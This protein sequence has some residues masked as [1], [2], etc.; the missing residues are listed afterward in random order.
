PMRLVNGVA[1]EAPDANV[2]IE[3][4]ARTGI[5]SNPDIYY[6]FT[7]MGTRVVVEQARYQGKLKNQSAAVTN[8]DGLGGT[9][10]LSTR[11]KP[12]LRAGIEYDQ[13][14]WTFWSFPTTE[15]DRPLNL[16]RGSH[17]QIKVVLHSERFDEFVRL[18]S[19]WIETSPIL[20]S[21]VVAE[22]AQLGQPNPAR[23]VA[24]VPLGEMT[25]F[26]YD[27]KAEFA[28]GEVGFDALR[29]STGS[30]Q[31]EFKALEVDGIATDPAGIE[32]ADNGFVVQ[33][34]QRISSAYSP[35]LR[36][37]FA[38]EVF[39]FARTFEG[40]VF[41]SGGTELP[42]PIESGDVSDA[43]GTNSLRVLAASAA[44]PQLV[45]DVQ[46]SSG[47]ITPNGDGVNDEL[48]ISYSLF[49]LPQSVPVQLQVFSLDGRQVAQVQHGQQGSGP[50]RLSWD[51]RDQ[52]GET[53]VPG[54]YL[55]GIGIEAEDKSALQL[56][57]INI[58]Y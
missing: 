5:D 11:P 13:Q 51:G 33:L 37:T 7:D 25:D 27:I 8:A 3:V 54:L 2:Q 53:L 19:L 1:E 50:Q 42:Q 48:V 23:G 34:P 4:E 14:N 28:A 15:S 46:F 6:E 26:T 29:I 52:R 49:A 38:A 18:D 31:T 16:N 9:L 30:T 56:R 21:R 55:L 41:N 32:V 57:P 40:E 17:L 35:N 44:N 45:Q 43:I 12:G 47:V 22:I 10:T 20:A 39:D 58:A 24:E 36:V